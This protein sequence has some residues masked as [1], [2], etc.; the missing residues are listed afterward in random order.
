[1]S[2][3]V[4]LKP[5]PP[6]EDERAF[7]DELLKGCPQCGSRK[8]SGKFRGRWEWTLHCPETCPS[9]ARPQDG[10][11]GHTIAAAAASR[12]GLGYRAIDGTA[13]GVVV[14]ATAGSAA[15]DG[16]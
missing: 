7:R 13:G 2:N 10:F 15:A 8:V 4:K 14:A 3:R 11:T 9:H 5:R 1:M 16:R 12:V 6:D